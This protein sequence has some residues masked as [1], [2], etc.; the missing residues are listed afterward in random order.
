MRSSATAS[1]VDLQ[2]GYLATR[3]D[4]SFRA[5][6]DAA[7]ACMAKIVRGMLSKSPKGIDD[8]YQRQATLDALHRYMERYFRN[9]DY[10]ASA[11]RALMVYDAMYILYDIRVPSGDRRWYARNAPIPNIPE[12]IAEVQPEREDIRW[13]L[14]DIAMG[15]PDYQ[16][17]LIT[18]YRAKTYRTFILTISGY[19]PRR[20]I[21][22][23]ARRLNYLYRMTRPRK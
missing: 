4:L 20:W 7:H 2:A 19:T 6:Y 11:P 12:V 15:H 5:F 16:H 14:L 13:A 9:P 22:D 23:Y 8:D 3:D 10:R 17:V 18:C 21:Y 1:L